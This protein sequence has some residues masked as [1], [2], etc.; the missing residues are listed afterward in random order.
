MLTDAAWMCDQ[1]PQFFSDEF[2]DWCERKG[3]TPRYGAVGQF[4]SIAVIERF[5]K[6]LKDE[7]LRRIMIPFTRERMRREVRL[8]ASWYSE[9]RPHQSLGGKTPEE[10]YAGCKAANE[11]PRWEPRARWPSESPCAQ[12]STEV[13]EAKSSRVELVLRFHGKRRQLPIVELKQAA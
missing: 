2:K 8:Y 12:P 5:F 1:G 9:H 7:W 11:K 3:T 6:S 10:V 13:R 4:G